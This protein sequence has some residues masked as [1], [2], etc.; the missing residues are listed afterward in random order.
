[1][2][3]STN[4]GETHAPLGAHHATGSQF[5]PLLHFLGGAFEGVDPRLAI[6]WRVL[7]A[8]E[9]SSRNVAD[10]IHGNPHD[11]SRWVCPR[12][13]AIQPDIASR[14]ALPVAS[15]HKRSS[16]L[17]IFEPLQCQLLTHKSVDGELVPLFL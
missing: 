9:V 10:R 1:M 17:V 8:Q 13:V 2:N 12:L 15:V 14:A 16:R 6:L 4:E 5:I 11:A 3:P 7:P